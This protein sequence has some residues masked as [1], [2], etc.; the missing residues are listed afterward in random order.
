LK[1]LYV[2]ILPYPQYHQSLVLKH[3]D[4]REPLYYAPFEL[5]SIFIEHLDS[6]LFF[7]SDKDIYFI[8]LCVGYA[9][10]YVFPSARKQVHILELP[11]LVSI[12][13]YRTLETVNQSAFRTVL[14]VNT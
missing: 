2:H 3:L 7:M 11:Y 14:K 1:V 8:L 12:P 10:V 13:F 9:Y 4:R 5:V 6:K